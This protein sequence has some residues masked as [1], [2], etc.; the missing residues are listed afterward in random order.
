MAR[1]IDKLLG[2]NYVPLNV[3]EVSKSS[4]IH[5]YK[6]LTKLA[7]IPVAPVLKSNAYG[8]GIELVGKI[9]D[10]LSPPMFCVDSIFE[11]YQLLKIKIKTPVL[12][13]G[14]VSGENLKIKKLPFSFSAY[15]NEMLE[16]VAKFQPQAPVHIF[17]DTGMHREGVPLEHLER[18]IR[19]AQKFGLKIAGLMSHSA[20]PDDPFHINTVRQIKNFKE[21][22]NI[23]KR[24][25]VE[26]AYIHLFASVGVMNIKNF[27]MRGNMARVGKALYGIDVVENSE[28]LRPALE[29]KSTIIQVK[30]L[31]KGERVGY[32]LVFKAPKDMVTAVLPIGYNDGVDR[33]LS[34]KG[35][36]QVNGIY[37]QIIGRVS[38]NIT[39]I[40]VT[41][42]K[43]PRVGQKVIIF[44]NRPKDKNSIFNVSQVCDAIPY[45]L[46]SHIYPTTRRVLAN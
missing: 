29:L 16:N 41:D 27:S 14:Y 24:L 19:K 25:G 30:D 2:K 6:Y 8:H 7:G 5:N 15:T 23:G 37:C 42:V 34:N 43:N 28:E 33:R 18:F 20:K 9:L 35:F 10:P 46:M 11:A 1:I 44:S 4:L 40:D 39:V 13:M 38:M 32:D 36:V 22:F 26:F 45:E 21:A 12:V 31:K 3:V 17:V